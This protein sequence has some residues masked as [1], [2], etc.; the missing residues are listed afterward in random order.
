VNGASYAQAEAALARAIQHLADNSHDLSSTII[1]MP[2]PKRNTKRSTNPYGVYEALPKT[3]RTRQQQPEE[4]LSIPSAPDSSPSPSHHSRPSQ[5]QTLKASTAPAGIIPACHPNYEACVAATHNCTGRGTCYKK[6][7]STDSG[8][9]SDCFAC[10]CVATVRE[11][12][13]GSKKTTQW[14]GAACQKKDVSMPFF[15]IA[16]FTVVMVATVSWGVGLLFS[17]G[18]ETLPSV[19]GA[20]VAGPRAHK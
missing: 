3:L 11:N 17:I 14:G 1:L 8:K 13:S 20:G 6:Y 9:A 7:S 18:Q 5:P 16:G 12:P 19:I 15:L 10:G 2:P 4:P